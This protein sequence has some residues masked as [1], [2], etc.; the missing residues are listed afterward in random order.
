MP[1]QVNTALV[2]WHKQSCCM[3]IGANLEVQRSCLAMQSVVKF[4]SDILRI[5][6]MTRHD[7]CTSNL[8][9]TAMHDCF[10][11]KL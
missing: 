9:P 1:I 3:G 10:E 6:H 11:L 4:L 2:S 8:L 7:R 5:F